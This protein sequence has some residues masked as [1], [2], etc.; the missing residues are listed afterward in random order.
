LPYPAALLWEDDFILLHNDA[1]EDM[2][3]IAAQGRPQKDSLSAETL[4][5]LQ[6]VRQQGIPKEVKTRDLLQE[7]TSE[8]K[9]VSTCIMSP[10]LPKG[11]MIQLLPKPMMYQSMQ[12]G[13][14]RPKKVNYSTVMND[15]ETSDNDHLPGDNIPIDEHPFFRR[16]A[17]ML[18]SGLA[19][20]DR[21]AQAIFVNQ[22]FFDLTTLQRDDEEFTSWPQSIHP[23]DYDRVMDAYKEAFQSQQE[24]R[25]EFRAKDEPHPWR[26]LLLT[27]LGDENLQHVSMRDN[28]G[29]ICSIVDISSEK[30]AELSERKA[31]QQARERKEQQ[32]RFIDM[33]SHEI[34]NPLS[35]VLH[36]AEDITEAIA[37]S[38]KNDIKIGMI[39]EAVETIHLCVKH[40][41]NIVDDVL[42]FSKLDASLLSLVPQLSDPSRQLQT[43]LKMFQH[44]FRKEHLEFEYI[45]DDSYDSVEVKD[46]MA[47]LPRI[48]QVLINLVTNAIKFTQRSSGQKKITCSVGA[49]V[50]RPKSYPTNVV[51][52]ESDSAAYKIDATNTKDWGSGPALYVMV[53]VK[54]TGIGISQEGQRRL[55]ERF[56]QAT[57]KTEEVYGG[58][59]LGLNISRKICHLH[60][61]EIGVS[62]KEGEG[63]TFGFYFKV[64][65]N[66]DQQ[67]AG[68]SPQE[69]QDGVERIRN[70]IHAELHSPISNHGREPFSYTPRATNKAESTSYFDEQPAKS[71]HEAVDYET[72]DAYGDAERPGI[73]KVHLSGESKVSEDVD[74]TQPSTIALPVR[75]KAQRQASRA[76]VLLVEDN[77]INQRIVFR[78]LEAK[79]FNVTTANNG[80][81]AV[82]K[83]RNA[84]KGSSGD[85]GAFDIILMDQ[86]SAYSMSSHGPR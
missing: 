81:E 19:I 12:I 27:P 33:I 73:S 56:R 24:L 79:G 47:D 13:G 16:F 43:T 20:L 41:K 8:S 42:S 66:E 86:V 35:A 18:P 50:E 51:K 9:Q 82:D 59:G 74:Q 2:G 46:V 45:V 29:F 85:K 1:W 5:T 77:I 72:D 62:S 80:K 15:D 71:S 63:S 28:G 65:R 54:D 10:L 14:E 76:H 84:P 83:A 11:V 78:K 36:C 68:P 48:G 38:D 37:V 21:N 3:G 25:V 32:E 55:F 7:I 53:A 61:G 17:E 4:A 58:S 70:Q 60:G 64:K 44:E 69:E 6:T 57:P 39:K 23:D 67:F 40:Q 75:Q 31:A 34:R 52:F 49:S 22:H 26:L 30:R